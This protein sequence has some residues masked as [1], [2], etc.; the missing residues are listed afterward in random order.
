MRL[1]HPSLHLVRTAL[2][3]LTLMIWG[4]PRAGAVPPGQ[5]PLAVVRMLS[6]GAS[7]T[8]IATEPGKTLLLG[9]GHAFTGRNRS[10]PIVIDVPTSHPGPAQRAGVQL[11][12]VDY[13]DDLSLVLLRAGPV[14]YCCPVA[15][16]G[17]RPGNL[18][19]VGYDEMQVPAKVLPAHIVSLSGQVTYTRE[20]PWHGRSGGGLIDADAGT[21]IGVVQGYELSGP[22]RGIYVSHQAILRFL[23][24]CRLR[25]IDPCFPQPAPAFPAPL[26]LPRGA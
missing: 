12:E 24:R 6:H 15:A 8:V 1:N 3:V 25:R 20:R 17:H 14:D 2:A 13:E 16:P 5:S 21:L 4:H 11:L 18:L 10:K 19:S 9:C 23:E 26:Y 7:A 22:R